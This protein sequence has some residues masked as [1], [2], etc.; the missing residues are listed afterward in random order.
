MGFAKGVGLCAL[1][2]GL[3]ALLVGWATLSF[4]TAFRGAEAALTT[5]TAIVVVGGCAAVVGA[6]L[7]AIAVVLQAGERAGGG[8]VRG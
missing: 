1:T 4:A 2:G 6:S 7:L 3:A 5:S 8:G